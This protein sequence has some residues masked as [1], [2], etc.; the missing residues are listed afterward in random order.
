[1]KKYKIIFVLFLILIKTC[2][3]NA[4]NTLKVIDSET[5]EPVSF[6][7]LNAD[8]LNTK[9]E[10]D[11]EGIINLEIKNNINYTF[12]RLGYK[13]L[14]IIG[15]QLS[16]SIIIEMESLPVELNTIV[17]T[18]NAAWLDLNRAIDNTF[19]SLPK[20][21]F[22]VKCYQNDKVEINNKLV[23]TGNATF[24]SEVLKLN[25]KGK[26]CKSNSKL[27]ELIVESNNIN[28]D[29]IQRLPYYKAPFV[30][31]FLIG[32]N[33]KYDKDLSFYYLD[34][35]DSILIIGYSPKLKFNPKN[36]VLT[37]G[38]YLIDKKKWKIIRID[39]DISPRML[40]FQNDEAVGNPKKVLLFKKFMRS[41]F[42]S[43][44]GLPTKLEEKLAYSLK[45]DKSKAI[46]VNSTTHIYTE[47]SKKEFSIVPLKKMENKSIIL[48]KSVAAP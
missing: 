21:P 18:A 16:N 6:A 44:R 35:N 2:V 40:D 17:I 46:W 42:F 26:G 14:H 3:L 12:S 8:E 48:Q 28:V 30:N 37:S 31:D 24:V 29:S 7:I 36:Y 22:Y 45:S 5:N 27:R 1:M 4:Q 20:L 13:S 15:S 25:A 9:F 38:R 23:A 43:D 11:L 47:I 10:A 34:I 39:S 33:R 32:E 19:S 41:I